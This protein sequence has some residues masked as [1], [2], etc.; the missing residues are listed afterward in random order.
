MEY[1]IRFSCVSHIG[2]VREI[3]QDNFICDG[4][5][6]DPESENP[7]F[8]LS[9]VK[10]ADQGA[11]FGVF[12]G[13]GGEEC[14]EVASLLA[15]KAAVG[16]EPG[17]NP[18]KTL[19]EFCQKAN[20]QICDYTKENDLSCVGTTAAMLAFTSAGITLCNIGDS[21][22]FRFHKNTLEQISQDHVAVVAYGRKPPLSQHLGIPAEELVIEPYF[23]MGKYRAEDVYLICSDGLTDLVDQKQIKA[24]LS[25][26][27]P[28]EAVKVLLA[29]ALDRGGKDNITII[30]CKVQRCSKKSWK[31]LR[32][33]RK[34][35]V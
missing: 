14:G 35:E 23:A 32:L 12:D 7:E 28:E 1:T 30:I 8:P 9:G 15:A 6:L 5:Y 18:V 4:H 22:V 25:N 34:R 16:L 26:N 29:Q 13:M 20:E 2:K 17:E 11:V 21:K 27:I 24:V 3:N 33:W 10:S 19:E 31:W